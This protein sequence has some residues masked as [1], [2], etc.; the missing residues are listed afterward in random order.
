MSTKSQSGQSTDEQDPESES[1]DTTRKPGE[2]LL[3]K[4]SEKWKVNDNVKNGTVTNVASEKATR[5][6]HDKLYVDENF[7]QVT[8]PSRKYQKEVE[9]RNVGFKDRYSVAPGEMKKTE[10]DFVERQVPPETCHKCSGETRITCTTCKG[11]GTETCPKCDGDGIQTCKDCSGK[12]TKKCSKCRGEG[13]VSGSESET[14]C[15][16][17]RGEGV[18]SC[19]RCN[20]SGNHDCKKCGGKRK[21]SCRKCG[22]DEIITC[23]VCEGDGE[24]VSAKAGSLEFTTGT[25]VE[26]RST[27]VPGKYVKR[28]DGTKVEKRTVTSGNTPSPNGSSTYR[29]TITEFEIPATKVEYEYNGTDYEFYEVEGDLSAS[30]FPKSQFRRILGYVGVI[31]CLGAVALGVL[32]F[33]GYI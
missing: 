10:A 1:P 23:P 30:T 9:E 18:N 24:L 28:G 12:G 17:C 7:S 21:I 14:Q 16:K 22:G 26:H 32:W 20:G 6:V 19:S 2:V 4:F 5:L 11:Q 3:V 15:P 27:H 33:L 25:E 8:Y 13:T 31:V 29:H